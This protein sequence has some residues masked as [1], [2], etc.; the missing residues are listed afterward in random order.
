VIAEAA[1][2]PEGD[3][4]EW[5]VSEVKATVV[6]HLGPVLVTGPVGA[7]PI[8]TLYTRGRSPAAVPPVERFAIGLRCSE[9][10]CLLGLSRESDGRN[11][12]GRAM[13]FPDMPLFEWRAAITRAA[14]E[15][16]T[17]PGFE[18]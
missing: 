9:E 2:L 8:R 11:F 13:L 7:T 1:S 17:Q 10:F 15:L 6:S 16:F 14:E 12:A 18:G 3:S 4:I 5:L